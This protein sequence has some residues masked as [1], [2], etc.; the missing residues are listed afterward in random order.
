M[1]GSRE[2]IRELGFQLQ[3]GPD[4]KVNPAST[5]W[6]PVIFSPPVI[7]PYQDRPDFSLSFH[8]EGDVPSE[9]IIP[10]SRSKPN[11]FI[12]FTTLALAAVGLLTTLKW[13]LHVVF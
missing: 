9:K 3:S 7:S 11:T 5:N 1:V 10:R 6:P 12:I 2:A 13:L 8:I 4:F